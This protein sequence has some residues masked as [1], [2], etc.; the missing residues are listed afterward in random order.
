MMKRAILL[1]VLCLALFN[2]P[3]AMA[4]CQRCLGNGTPNAT[5]WTVG[6][7]DQAMYGAC[8]EQ[9]HVGPNGTVDYEQCIGSAAG[10]DCNQSCGGGGG[11]AGGGGGGGGGCAYAPGGCPADCS[12]CGPMNDM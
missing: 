4:T 6:P 2:A 1:S 10:S 7:C 3:N 5:C 9:Q 12:S 8:W 11:G